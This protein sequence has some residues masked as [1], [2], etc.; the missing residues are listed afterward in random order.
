MPVHYRT[1]YIRK[2]IK[3]QEKDKVRYEKEKAAAE[4]KTTSQGFARG[5]AVERR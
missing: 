5:P 1:F 3:D 2:L 4:G